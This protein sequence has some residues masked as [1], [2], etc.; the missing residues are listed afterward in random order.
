VPTDRELLCQEAAALADKIKQIPF[1]ALSR[2][3]RGRILENIKAKMPVQVFEIT[4]LKSYFTF[5]F[6]FSFFFFPDFS[7]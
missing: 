4:E 2:N 1:T 7:T 6:F 5:F 3:S